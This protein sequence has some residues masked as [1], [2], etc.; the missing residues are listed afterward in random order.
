MNPP[1]RLFLLATA[2]LAAPALAQETPADVVV[3]AAGA[4]Q[5]V[6]ETGEAITVVTRDDLEAR[7]TVSTADYLAP[8]T[9]LSITRSGGPGKIRTDAC[10]ERG[11][12]NG[13]HRGEGVTV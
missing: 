12:R 11:G 3:T 9:G 13:R 10:R 8:P 7:Q 5:S 4:P 6:K 1:Y 2:A